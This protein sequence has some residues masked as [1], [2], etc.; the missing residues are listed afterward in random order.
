MFPLGIYLGFLWTALPFL[1]ERAGVSV[2]RIAHLSAVLQLPGM[3]LFLWTPVVDLKLRR[4]TWLLVGAVGVAACLV[5]ASPL[6]TPST[7]TLLS[8][9]LLLGGVVVALVPAACG[10]MMAT[11]LPAAAQPRA[12]AWNQAGQL[13]GGALGGAVAIWLVSRTSL[14]WMGVAIASLALVPASLALTISEPLVSPSPWFRGRFAVLRHEAMQLLRSPARRWSALLLITPCCTGAAQGLLPALASHYGISATGVI[15]T[16]GLGGGVVLALGAL[17]AG[18]VPGSWDR[19]LVYVSSGLANGL[20]A[21]VLLA[22]NRPSVYVGGTLLYL[23]TTGFCWARF[24]S[25]ALAVIGPDTRDA[26]TWYGVLTSAGTVPVMCMIWLDGT[27]FHA[28]G[29]HGLLWTDAVPNL[30]VFAL[31][32]ALLRLRPLLTHTSATGTPAP[33]AVD[34]GAPPGGG[35]E[36]M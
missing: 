24:V 15:W 13:G 7:L 4:R 35:I 22:S 30:L 9:A 19:R 6:L 3:L 23:L 26:S 14:T 2:E 36:A 18:L 31:V 32:L 17:C 34:G 11:L 29:V 12:S 27:G 28:F 1:L 16:N 20:A 33:L 25:L 5:G 10:G 21:M 8:G